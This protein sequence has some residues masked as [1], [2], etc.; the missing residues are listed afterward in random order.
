LVATYKLT[1]HFDLYGGLNYSA[2]AGGL[3][4][5]YLNTSAFGQMG[6]VRFSF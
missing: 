6:G 2:V 5:G 4:S 1:R 3:A